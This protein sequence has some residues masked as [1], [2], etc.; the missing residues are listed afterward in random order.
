MDSNEIDGGG[1]STGIEGLSNI[2]L[3]IKGKYPTKKRLCLLGVSI[4]ERVSSGLFHRHYGTEYD[5][6]AGSPTG[7]GAKDNNDDEGDLPVGGR[8]FD[9]RIGDLELGVRPGG[10]GAG[11]PDVETNND[12]VKGSCGGGMS[13]GSLISQ[14]TA[15]GW[16][17]AANRPGLKA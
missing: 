17:V 5:D 1:Q 14:R 6:K 10:A 4:A 8:C 15:T 12:E 11:N 9:S 13:S 3:M 7:F 16:S 2:Y